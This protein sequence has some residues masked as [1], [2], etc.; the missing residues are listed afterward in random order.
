MCASRCWPGWPRGPDSRDEDPA[1][2]AGAWWRTERQTFIPL[3]GLRQAVFTIGVESQPLAQAIDTPERAARLHAAIAS[4]TPAVLQ[5]RGLE[6]VREPLL[7]WL[8]ER[9]G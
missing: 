8:A 2:P 1:D 3:P 6:G 7:A 5:Y 4:M 9:A